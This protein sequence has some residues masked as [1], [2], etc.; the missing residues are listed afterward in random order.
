[1]NPLLLTDFYKVHHHRMYP[2]G[3]TLIY[4][5][6]T[7]RKSRLP[8]VDG[9]VFFGLQ[10]FLLEYLVGRFERDFFARPLPD[11]LAEYERH[12]P[13]DTAHVAEL[14]TLGYLPLEIK[15][16]PE[17]TQCP[18]GVPCLTIRNTHPAFGWL[19]NYL[20]TLLSCQLWQPIT[21]ATLARQ[22][23]L[24]LDRY[25]RQ[26]TGTTD[27]VQWQAHDFSMRGMSSVETAVLSGMGHLLAFT[28]TDSIPAIYQLEASYDATGLI[29]ASVPATEHSV[30][31]MGTKDDELGTFRELLATFPEGIL[32]VVS[33]TWD[34]WK[35]CTEYLPAL[36]AE[37]LARDGKLVIR[38]DSGDPVDI[39]CGNATSP[40]GS[41]AAKGVVELLWDTFGGT[42]NAQGYKML[43][44]H[45][46]AIYGD[47][48]NLARAEDICERL[49]A[50]GFAS[51]NVVLGVGSF[52][53]QYN[54]RD[55][56]GFAMKATYG[57]V[58]LTDA[59]GAERTEAREIFKDPITDDG[60]K[61][62]KKGLLQVVPGADGRLVCHDQ[63]TPE[64]EREGALQ[65]VFLNG[66]LLARTT[67]AEIRA[68]LETE[69]AA[70]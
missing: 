56:F 59:T 6:L 1:M 30:M 14:H 13:V 20:E 10:H 57:E 53:Y 3:T 28:G 60:T 24:L 29:G 31:C 22:F 11:V 68:R 25:A 66:A 45:I 34:L 27:G 12:V 32:S 44:P 16:L 47:S 5:N 21:S 23:R 39:L 63:C 41:P 4:S 7:P 46:G 19:T 55:T 67:L 8:G 38:P 54:T 49:K 62:S 43:S 61:R 40:V 64:Q 35:V 58:R 37:I 15:A 50:K 70:G 42:T 17:G 52:T 2:E 51:T 48:I 9:I 36:K 26:T 33:D 69:L 18:I 65:P